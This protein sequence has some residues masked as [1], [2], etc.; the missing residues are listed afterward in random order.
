[1]PIYDIGDRVRCSVAFTN[2]AGAAAD[3][4]TI[5]FKVRTPGGTETEY[6]YG[7]NAEVV[8]TATGA[9]YVDVTLTAASDW[10][11]RFVASGSIVTATEQTVRVRRTAFSDPL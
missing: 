4:T 6:V 7:V 1:M 3:P 11:V 8:R 5:A 9:Y 10:S 2:L